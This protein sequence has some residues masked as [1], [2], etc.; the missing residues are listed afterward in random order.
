V[1]EGLWFLEGALHPLHPDR[2][3]RL[4]RQPQAREFGRERMITQSQADAGASRL[5]QDAG[6][7]LGEGRRSAG[8]YLNAARVCGLTRWAISP[9]RASRAAAS[10]S[11]AAARCAGSCCD[12]PSGSSNAR[13]AATAASMSA[14]WA[15][16]TEPMAH[17]GADSPGGTE[18]R[19][20]HVILLRPS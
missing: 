4:G 17:V 2:G 14:S 19:D 3:H 16:G 11:M 9:A 7:A 6:A 1:V 12:Q 18:D 5:E 20:S 15:S 10:L 13:A 8:P